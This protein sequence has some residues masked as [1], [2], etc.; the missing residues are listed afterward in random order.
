MN[1]PAA[2]LIVGALAQFFGGS[3]LYVLNT[4]KR[5][6]KPNRMTFLIWAAGPFIGVAAATAAGVAWWILLPVFVSGLGPLAIFL[7]SFKNPSAY[8]KLGTIDYACGALAVLALIL[9]AITTNPIIAIVFAITADGLASYPTILK[10][11]KYP[12]TETG[13]TYFIALCN[14]TLGLLVASH[15]DF[16]HIGFLVYLFLC[17]VVL[18]VAIYRRRILQVVGI[19]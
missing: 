9:W 3:L 19:R 12:E 13:T 18:V 10:C 5:K 1:W 14:V 7:A 15:Y 17:D 6:S 16:L 4:L 2:I 8:W 11:W